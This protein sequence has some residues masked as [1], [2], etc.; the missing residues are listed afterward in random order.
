MGLKNEFFDRKL[1]VNV[2]AFYTDYKAILTGQSGVQCIA[3]AN[4]VWHP[5]AGDCQT[6]YPADP[7]YV[8]WSITTGRPGKIKGFEWDISA[9]PVRGLRVDFSGGYNDFESGVTTPG[10]PG[11][12]YPGNLRNPE[13]NMHGGAH[14]DLETS[15]GTFTPR[16]DWQWTSKANFGPCSGSCAPTPDF[17][18]PAYSLFNAGLEYRAK[19]GDWS[20]VLSVTNLT[21]KFY[22]Y[23]LFNGTQ[24]NISSPVGP[25]REISL[26]VRRNF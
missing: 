13:W 24:T 20:A 9:A 2:S 22:F 10:L 3:E 19:G 18:I 21:D 17:T 25:P 15:L 26:T 6:L 7:S 14:Y 23:Q 12:I 11:Y 1:R 5:A 4:P 8:P 16:I